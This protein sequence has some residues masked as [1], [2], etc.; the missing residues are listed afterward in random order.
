MG[1]LSQIRPHP[2][3]I[4]AGARVGRISKKG[5]DAGFAGAEIRYI[6]TTV[7]PGQKPKAFL[8]FQHSVLLTVRHRFTSTNDS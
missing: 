2:V 1:Q 7:M 5:P 6:P 4:L 8:Q 3:K